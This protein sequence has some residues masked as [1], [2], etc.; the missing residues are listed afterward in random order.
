[1]QKKIAIPT[2][3]NNVDEHF[4]HCEYYTVYSINEGKVEKKEILAS[5]F[6]N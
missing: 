4:G 5:I 6:S 1:M 2:R 3:G